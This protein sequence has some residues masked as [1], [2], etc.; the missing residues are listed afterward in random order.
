MPTPKRSASGLDPLYRTRPAGDAIH[1]VHQE[2]YGATGFNPT[3]S[4]G[5]FRPVWMGP[6]TARVPVPTMYGAQ[7]VETAIA[8]GLLRGVDP[9]KRAR[10]RLFRHEVRG[11]AYSQLIPSRDLNLVRLNGPGLTR[12]GLTRA[13]VIDSDKSSY[14]ATAELAQKLHDLPTEP[15]GILWTSRQNDS[16]AAMILWGDRVAA[17][18]LQHVGRTILLDREPGLELVRVAALDGGFDFEG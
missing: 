15:D 6:P 3:A 10:R 13:D 5:R 17:P 16:A 4:D 14:P 11:V 2:S 7:D 8:E 1:R 12:L 18:D 9:D